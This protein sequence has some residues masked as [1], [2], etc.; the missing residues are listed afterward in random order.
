MTKV[1]TILLQ[2]LILAVLLVS[3]GSEATGNTIINTL[4]FADTGIWVAALTIGAG[5][6]VILT[7]FFLRNQSPFTLGMIVIISGFFGFP[8][9]VVNAFTMP[10]LVRSLALGYLLMTLI[11][12]YGAALRGEF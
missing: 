3:S 1:S 6:T 4:A 9:S 5:V 10:T 11:T 12:A 8:L 7:A 2:W